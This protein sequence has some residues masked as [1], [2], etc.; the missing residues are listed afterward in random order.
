MDITWNTAEEDKD[1]SASD[2]VL[3]AKVIALLEEHGITI[4][5]DWESA[6]IVIV[7]E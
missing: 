7:K 3:D 6:V 5:D 1:V 2:A 4:P